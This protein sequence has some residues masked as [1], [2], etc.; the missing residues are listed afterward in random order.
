MDKQTFLKDNYNYCFL[1]SM[2]YLTRKEHPGTIITG[3]SYGA[4]GILMSGLR[5]KTINFSVRSQDLYY[6]FCHIRKAVQE[7]E[8]SIEKCVI[9]LAYYSLYYDLSKTVNKDYCNSVYYPLFGDVHN[10]DSQFLNVKNVFEGLADET[11]EEY[12]QFYYNYFSKYRCFFGEMMLRE[13]TAPYVNSDMGWGYMSKEDKDVYAVNIAMVKH[14]NH[15]KHEI[16]LKE[17]IDIFYNVMKFLK[18]H[19]IKA[20]VVILPFSQEYNKYIHPKYEMVLMEQLD[21]LPFEIDYY[22]FNQ[23][24]DF[25]TYDFLD[26]D[27]L[28]EKGANKATTILNYILNDG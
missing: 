4:D 10:L 25:T 28:N 21:K 23:L 16:T 14:G 9:T 11:M 17:N 3:M 13:D 7:S 22:D 19:N 5:N 12:K 20:Y 26:C 1:D 24:N 8:G 15:M 27:H 6:D 18:D 2:H